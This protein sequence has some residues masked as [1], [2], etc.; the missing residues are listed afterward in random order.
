MQHRAHRYQTLR[1]EDVY[2]TMKDD[3][4]KLKLQL[5]NIVEIEKDD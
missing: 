4:S 5:D 3:F 2:Y 1:M